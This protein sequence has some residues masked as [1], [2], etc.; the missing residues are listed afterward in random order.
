[1]ALFIPR[2]QGSRVAEHRCV[3]WLSRCTKA[4]DGTERE[5]AKA[6]STMPHAT[7]NSSHRQSALAAETFEPFNPR[8]YLNEYYRHLDEANPRMFTE[9]DTAR[10]LEFGGGPTIYQLISAAKYPASID[11]SDY[12]DANL[13]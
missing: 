2:W 9:L 3:Q 13:N 1:M 12:L 10:V 5:G 7:L 6:R 4:K 8:A 11:F